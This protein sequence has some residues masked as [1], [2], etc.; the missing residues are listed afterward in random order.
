MEDLLLLSITSV[1]V[2]DLSF[3]VSVLSFRF[4][5][6]PDWLSSIKLTIDVGFPLRSDI[7]VDMESSC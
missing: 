2:V 3:R 5:V 4:D 1:S 6:F 7:L